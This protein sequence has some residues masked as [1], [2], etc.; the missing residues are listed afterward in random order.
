MDVV[1]FI[2]SYGPWAWILGGVVLLALELVL[3]GGFFLWLGISGIV[4]GLASMFQ[5]IDWPWQVL[6]FGALSLLTIFGWLRYSRGR[7]QPS[8]RPLLNERAAQFIGREALLAEP[9]RGGFGRIAF[10]DTTWRVAGP[11]LA[12]GERV[13][14]VGY[15]GGVLQVEPA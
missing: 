12:A 3:P 11:D 9:I 13:R 8:D 1:N 15:E 5:P 7:E 14:V 6:I 10:G 4:T 2:A